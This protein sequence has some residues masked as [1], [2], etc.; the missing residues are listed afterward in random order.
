[1]TAAKVTTTPR[2]L[3]GFRGVALRAFETA[4]VQ[5]QIYSHGLSI[6]MMVCS[7]FEP[8]ARVSEATVP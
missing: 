6:D 2:G 4:H 7:A 5:Q 8:T 1:M 3:E